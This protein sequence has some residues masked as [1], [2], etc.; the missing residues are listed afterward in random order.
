MAKKLNFLILLVLITTSTFCQSSY[1][2]IVVVGPD[3]V[4]TFSKEQV[5]GLAI[6]KLER[7][8]YKEMSD[9]CYI[10]AEVMKRKIEVQEQII[11][12]F[13]K[14]LDLSDS[15]IQ[16]HKSIEGILQNDIL[17][18]DDEIKRLRTKTWLLSTIVVITTGILIWK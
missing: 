8:M 13:G 16:Q 15:I 2:K 11:V 4:V 1:P 18:K 6:T 7:N 17:I 12:N 9:S 14:Q 3:T 5:K 10:N